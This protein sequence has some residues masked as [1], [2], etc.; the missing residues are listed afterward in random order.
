MCSSTLKNMNSNVSQLSNESNDKIRKLTSIKSSD[1]IVNFN[2]NYMNISS[3]EA[4]I[5]AS[6]IETISP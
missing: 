6:R 5:Y 3:R 2:E 4:I 1:R